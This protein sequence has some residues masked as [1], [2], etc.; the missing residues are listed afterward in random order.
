MGVPCSSGEEPHVKAK[1]GE[2]IQ[3]SFFFPCHLV[4]MAL[5]SSHGSSLLISDPAPLGRAV[6]PQMAAPASYA[7]G[8][9]GWDTRVFRLLWKEDLQLCPGSQSSSLV[10]GSYPW[11]LPTCAVQ[12]KVL[13]PT[14]LVLLSEF[15]LP[16]HGTREGN[17]NPLQYS[18]LENPRDRG[19]WW[20]AFVYGVTQSQTRLKQ[21]SSSSSHGTKL[22]MV[23]KSVNVFCFLLCKM[24]LTVQSRT[25]FLKHL[26]SY[27][28]QNSEFFS[29]SHETW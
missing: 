14:A 20:A 10:L 19:A 1:L 21:L 7:A 3:N 8:R 5:L 16:S 27:I 28:L 25:S 9:T 4:P 22:G 24:E 2:G 23:L 29:F 26:G 17:G 13:K 11:A 18:C 12:N 15:P 6:S